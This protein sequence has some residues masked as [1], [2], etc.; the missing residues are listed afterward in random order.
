MRQDQVLLVA[1]ADL[2]EGVALGDI[3]DR[4]HLGVAGVAGRFAG[5]LERDGHAA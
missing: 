2:V 1:D 4:I 3:G 5:A